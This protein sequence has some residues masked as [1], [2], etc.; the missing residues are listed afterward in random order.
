MS[1]VF[2]SYRRVDTSGSAGRLFDRLNARWGRAAVFMDIEG[3][4]PRGDDFV[5]AIARTLE[6]ADAMLVVIGPR[7]LTCTD[8]KGARRLDNPD[9]WVRNEIEAG[10]RRGI[11]VLPVLVDGASIP[12]VDDLP[13]SL[14]ALARRQSSEITNSR[15]NHDVGEIVKRLEP[16][17]VPLP[18]GLD[19]GSA[20]TGSRTASRFQWIW[21]IGV[22]AIAFAVWFALERGALSVHPISNLQTESS[23]LTVSFDVW[24]DLGRD[25]PELNV[26]RLA[27]EYVAVVICGSPN[28]D[29]R[30]IN[31]DSVYLS[32]G[33]GSGVPAAMYHLKDGYDENNDGRDDLKLDYRIADLRSSANKLFTVSTFRLTGRLKDIKGVRPIRGERT[34]AV[35]P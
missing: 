19:V 26:V 17:L 5:A 27:H 3:G 29:V 10:L 15:W 18:Q 13:P 16:P 34:V 4:I 2:V 23:A 12:K 33:T 6:S 14:H 9:D 20:P 7:W 28:L 35:I 1:G 31:V 22:T 21:W 32:D 30:D 24:Q 11:P 25:R 8:P